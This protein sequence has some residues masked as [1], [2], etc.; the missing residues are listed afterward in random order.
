MNS[1]DSS[2]HFGQFGGQYVIETLMPA[3]KKL[4]K[5]FDKAMRDQKFHKLLERYNSTYIGRPTPLYFAERL[6]AH[7]GGARIYLKREDLGFILL[8]TLLPY[9]LD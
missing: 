3:L 1:P 4:D 7:C 6:T 5:E 9:Q 2:G 8:I